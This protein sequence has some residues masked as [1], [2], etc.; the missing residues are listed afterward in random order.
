MAYIGATELTLILPAGVSI[1]TNTAPLTIGEVASIVFEIE[2]DLNS[3]AAA[4]GYDVPIPTGATYAFAQMQ[5]QTKNGAG[6][7]V[8]GII[9][10]QIGG[11]GDKSSLAADYRDAYNAFK[12]GLAK[13]TI[14]L[15]DVGTG[16]QGV[17]LPRSFSVAQGDAGTAG[18]SAFIPMQWAP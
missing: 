16:D 2:A 8:L 18:A 15:I 14:S 5:L 6:W 4:V 7:R 13:G 10:P 1:G 17:E 11:P 12:T 9:F 3:V